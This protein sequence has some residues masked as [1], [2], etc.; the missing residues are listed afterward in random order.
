[1][2]KLW[3]V[4][5]PR[6]DVKLSRM[7]ARLC[8]VVLFYSSV[9]CCN[10]NTFMKLILNPNLTYII[11]FR[12]QI[13]LIFCTEYGSIISLCSVQKFQTTGQLK[14]KWYTHKGLRDLNSQ[15]RLTRGVHLHLLAVILP[16]H[17]AFSRRCRWI[18]IIDVSLPG[19]L[20]PWE[21]TFPI[22]NAS[23]LFECTILSF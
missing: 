20:A 14:S 21:R 4:V 12:C 13:V 6:T 22:N 1:M 16:N 3:V 8:F 10:R 11:H 2:H 19:L 9:G 15:C 17:L 18:S 7:E 5:D 23:Y